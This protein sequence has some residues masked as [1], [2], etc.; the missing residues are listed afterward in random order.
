MEQLLLWLFSFTARRLIEKKT[1][2]EL[3]DQLDE[4]T[5]KRVNDEVDAEEERKFRNIH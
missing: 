2:E 4:A 5:R 3:H 1:D